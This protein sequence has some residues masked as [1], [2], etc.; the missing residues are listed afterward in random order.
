MDFR[1]SGVRSLKLNIFLILKEVKTNLI[2]RSA[3]QKLSVKKRK[4]ELD[5]S[6]LRSC[7]TFNVFPKFICFPLPNTNRFNVL[8]IRKRL[9]RSAI[10]K[11]QK[12]LNKLSCDCDK[13][14]ECLKN[15]L[16]SVDWYLL[17]KA[18]KNNVDKNIS[19]AISTHRKKLKNLTRT[20]NYPSHRTKL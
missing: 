4:A 7:K 19:K 13:L 10:S 18:L 2:L 6:F 17:N 12:E 1:A 9:L 11:R 8:A 5:V 16:N 20:P 3:S 15:S 14:T